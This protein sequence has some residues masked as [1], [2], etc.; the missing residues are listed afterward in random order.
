LSPAIAI[1]WLVSVVLSG[2]VFPGVQNIDP[3]GSFGAWILERFDLLTV[4]VLVV[5]TTLAIAWIA[6]RIADQIAARPN[7][8]GSLLTGGGVAIA[9]VMLLAQL[10]GVLE[11][12]RPAI[13][14][15]VELAAIDL[16]TSPDPQGPAIPS[17]SATPIRAIVFGTDDHRIFPVL[18]VQAV[19]GAGPHTLYV[20]ADLLSHAW[21]RERLRAQVPTL[22]DVDK[23]L[24]LMGAIWSDPALAQVPIYL[25]NVFSRPASQLP[26]VPEGMLWRVPPPADHPVFEPSEWTHDKILERHLAATARMQIRPEDFGGLTHPRGHPWS[27]DLW[28]AYVDKAQLLASTLTR[29]GLEHALPAIRE[30]LEQHTGGSF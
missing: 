28:F 27:A 8:R 20:D 2:V 19:L 15:G 30:A 14:R 1:G 21:Y 29:A 6:D 4:L 9:V 12:G 22:P 26:K 23:P 5:P 3:T 18:Y 11:R 17:A 16:V 24:K 7:V 13:E 25:A 10:G